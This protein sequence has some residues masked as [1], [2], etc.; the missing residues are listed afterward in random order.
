M[1]KP[2]PFAQFTHL[3]ASACLLILATPS[4]A[5]SD[6]RVGMA[7]WV[8]CEDVCQGVADQLALGDPD[9]TFV[10]LDAGRDLDALALLPDVA[11]AAD[12]DLLLAWGTRVTRTMVGTIDEF[13][14]GSRM[15]D[16]PVVFTVP[17]DPVAS[18]II[19]S[20]ETPGRRQITG[21]RNRVPEAANINGLRKVLPSFDHLGLLYEPDATNSRLKFEELTALSGEMGFTLSAMPLTGTSDEAKLARMKSDLQQMKA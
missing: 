9:I 12:L 11:K 1:T 18:D 8:G 4:L 5:G 13:G 14:T 16:I 2:S 19:A 20:Y 17:A 6:K 15:G 3:I 7:L 10:P 21:T